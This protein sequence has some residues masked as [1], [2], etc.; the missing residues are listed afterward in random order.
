MNI[1]VPGGKVTNEWDQR[2]NTSQHS[3]PPLKL[4]RCRYKVAKNE[5]TEL[6]AYTEIQSCTV[7]KR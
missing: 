3:L 5:T 6:V 4:Y 1:F 2:S 7:S